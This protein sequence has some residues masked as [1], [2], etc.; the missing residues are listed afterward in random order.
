MKNIYK[1]KNIDK[2]RLAGEISV[3]SAMIRIADPCYSEDFNP[4]DLT[5]KF[6]KDGILRN[7]H[8]VVI[9]TPHGDGTYP[10]YYDEEEKLLIVSLGN[11][12]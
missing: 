9:M 7:E 3:D 1:N 5:N 12:D 4:N 11:S 8:D 6:D 10:V 2:L